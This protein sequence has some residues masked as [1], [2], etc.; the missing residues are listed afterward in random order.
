MPDPQYIIPGWPAPAG[1]RAAA[2]TRRGGFSKG[3]YASLNLGAAAGD[4][5]EDV[6]GNRR[7]LR[8]ALGLGREPAWLRQ[9]HGARTVEACPEQ[10]PEADACWTRDPGVACAIL[11]ADC[12]PVL[13][14]D[15][16]GS[17]VG[18]AHGGWRG[19]A[20]G[21]IGEAVAA[22]PAQPAD[23]LAWLGP[24]IG[25]ERFEVGPE[26]REAL[27]A[28]GAPE[29]AFRDSGRAGHF[30]CDLYAIAR[31]QLHQAGVNDV[32]G[33]GFCTHSEADRF[34]SYRRDGTTGRMA[35]LVWME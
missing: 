5:P 27:L 17:C 20:A 4:D 10:A 6:R 2:T 15:R 18:A 34:Y 12:L 8:E 31:K 7:L 29:S 35:T 25:P 22:L 13:M 1:V 30:L 33:G 28:G 14:C 26:V 3:P 21:V 24:A 9:V 23:L 11:A 19:L 16:R 32:H